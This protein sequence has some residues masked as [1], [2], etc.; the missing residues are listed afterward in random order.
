MIET[1]EVL[2]VPSVPADHPAVQA[3]VQVHQAG[4]QAALR[5]PFREAHPI[6]FWSGVGAGSLAAVGG[7]IWAGLKLSRP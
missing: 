3:V 4:V 2:R 7:A 1:G 5:P 6:L